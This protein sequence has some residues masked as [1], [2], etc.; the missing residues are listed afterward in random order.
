MRPFTYEEEL[1][2]RRCLCGNSVANG[3]RNFADQA[4]YYAQTWGPRILAALIIL[5]IGWA[6]AR[7]VKWAVASLLNKSPLGRQ[8]NRPDVHERHPS[9]VGAQVGN[10]ACWVILLVAVFL[11]AQ[12]LGLASATGPLGDMLRGFSNAFPRII[13]AVLIFFLGYAI[14]GVAKK[15]VEAVV[16]ASHVERFSKKVGTQAPS[17]PNLL[18]R[19]L[20][21][22]AFALI[23]IPVAIAA[24]DTLN[25]AAISQPATAMLGSSSMPFRK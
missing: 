20:G 22:I 10:A 14:A 11:A 12:P 8:A 23:I 24:L 9:T 16:T 3:T 4:I 19:T 25:I 21:S 6:T 7:A 1:D 13:G 15:A 2:V 17:D 18:P 5:L